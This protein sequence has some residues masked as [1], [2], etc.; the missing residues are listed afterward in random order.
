MTDLHRELMQALQI[1]Q[2]LHRS[3]SSIIIISAFSSAELTR[4]K[5][6]KALMLMERMMKALVDL[7]R[8]QHQPAVQSMKSLLKKEDA[9]H[10]RRL[11]CGNSLCC[12][13]LEFF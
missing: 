1:Y 8:Q 6:A 9:L 5:A 3:S 13:A 10:A 7:Q 11:Y 2:H 12:N 4:A